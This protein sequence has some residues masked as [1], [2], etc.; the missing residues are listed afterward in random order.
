MW[1]PGTGRRERAP[2]F[3]AL[4]PCAALIAL[5][6]TSAHAQT[7]TPDLFRPVPGGFV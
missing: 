4:L 6:G 1:G 3:R 2:L 7:L 5:G